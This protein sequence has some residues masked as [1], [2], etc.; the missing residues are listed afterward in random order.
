MVIFD[1]KLLIQS[2]N[3]KLERI[4]RDVNFFVCLGFILITIMV[5]VVMYFF[6]IVAGLWVEAVVIFVQCII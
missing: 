3:D 1:R 5:T 2:Q 4:Y 6:S